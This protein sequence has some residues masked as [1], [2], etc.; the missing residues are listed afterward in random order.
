[1]MNNM[2]RQT[3]NVENFDTFHLLFEKSMLNCLLC[4]TIIEHSFEE[5]HSMGRREMARRGAL[6]TLNSKFLFTQNAGDKEREVRTNNRKS[7]WR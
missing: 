6:I 3:T 7:K 1:M 4:T 2:K 5:F